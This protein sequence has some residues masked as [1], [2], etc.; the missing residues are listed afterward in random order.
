MRDNNADA[1]GSPSTPATLY[2]YNGTSSLFTSVDNG[3]TWSNTYNGFPT[4]TVPIFAIATPPRGTAAAG[5]IW[6]FAGWQLHHS[7][8]GGYNWSS[9]WQFYSVKNTIAVGPLPNGT[10]AKTDKSAAELSAICASKLP[11][12]RQPKPATSTLLQ[13]DIAAGRQ[14]AYPASTATSA[15]YAVY[16]VGQLSY[17]DAQYGVYGSVD[18][19]NTWVAL[20]TATQGLG[21]DPNVVE[22]SLQSPGTIF[23]GTEGRGAFYSDVSA[24]LMEALEACAV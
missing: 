6:A 21:D 13:S 5:D 24:V 11:V 19:G 8:N 12:D 15:A 2:Y 3:V 1:V 16:A 20:T 4:W 7:T 18:Y 10:S 23:V 9:A 14:Y 22:A 17:N